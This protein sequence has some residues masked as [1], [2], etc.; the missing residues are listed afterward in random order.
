MTRWRIKTGELKEFPA[1]G[2]V[3]AFY[4][5]SFTCENLDTKQPVTVTIGQL[6]GGPASDLVG[7]LMSLTEVLRRASEQTD[8]EPAARLH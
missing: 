5:A 1:E 3:A 7:A 4:T 6:Q 2:N 8:D